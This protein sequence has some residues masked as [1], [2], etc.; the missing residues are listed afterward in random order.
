MT[1]QEFLDG[2]YVLYDEV[3][4][5]SAPGFTPPELSIIVSKIQEDLAITKYNPKSNKVQEGFEETEKRI[6]DLGELVKYKTYTVFT[7][8]FFDNSVEILLPNTL[9][10]AGPTD[11]SDVYWFTIYEDIKSNQLDCSIPNNTTVYVRPKISDIVHGELKVA[12]K[13]PF[14]KPYI[15]ADDGKVLRVRAEGRKHLLIT[16]GSF[17]ITEYRIGYVRK[18]LPIDFTTSLTSQVSE[19]ADQTHRELLDMTVNYCLGLTKQVEQMSINE[20]KP[21][22]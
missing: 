7:S 6:Q 3:A 22:E 18:P 15:K 17:N 16:D 8:G 13:D 5:L 21:I 14:R 9:V 20:R 19:L 12:L 10:T 2:F 1:K 4:D 11:F